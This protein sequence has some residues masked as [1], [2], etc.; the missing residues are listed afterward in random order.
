[1]IQ[2]Q[3]VPG[4]STGMS[5]GREAAP[6]LVLAAQLCAR[7]GR[8]T[9]QLIP[10]LAGAAQRLTAIEAWKPLCFTHVN[11]FA[12]ERL[13][14]SGSWLRQLARLGR[15]CQE[16]PA[17]TDAITGADGGK[18][19][20]RAA[21]YEICRVARADTVA[22]WIQRARQG[23]IRE[24]KEA[25]RRAQDAAPASVAATPPARAQGAL[26]VHLPPFLVCALLDIERVFRATNPGSRRC[27]L[28]EALTA[29]CASGNGSGMIDA[30]RDARAPRATASRDHNESVVLDT[31]IA[32]DK[33]VDNTTNRELLQ[34]RW[35]LHRV[36]LFIA[37]LDAQ[38]KAPESTS[39]PKHIVRS[40]REILALEHEV[41]LRI[42]QLLLWLDHRRAWSL[43]GTADA[44]DFGQKVLDESASTTRNRLRL[45][46]ALEHSATL[47]RGAESGQV[48]HQRLVRLAQLMKQR[49]LD[50][51][52]LQ[53]WVDHAPQIRIKRLDDEYNAIERRRWLSG[54]TG[55]GA[56][57]PLPLSDAEW[58]A[59]LRLVP[60]E[61][62]QRL[63]MG[64]LQALAI[65]AAA[66][67]CHRFTGPAETIR[68][69]RHSLNL[70]RVR[71]AEQG[72]QLVHS[73]HPGRGSLS[74]A[75]E[76][77]LFPSIRLAAR[78]VEHGTPIPDWVCLLSLLEEFAEEW[79]NPR[80][81]PRR[82]TDAI[83]ARDGWRCTAPGCTSREIEIHHIVYRSHGGSDDP[84]NL[85]SI[86]PFHHRMG[87]HGGLLKVTGTA[88]LALRWQIGE[89]VFV[90][91]R[92]FD[93]VVSETS[94]QTRRKLWRI[95]E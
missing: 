83:A 35:T 1:M 67:V 51:D 44:A 25:I 27:D 40:M 75:D 14:H 30:R 71:L 68:D 20:G 82:P 37:S 85:T 2:R 42:D 80:H 87:E 62:R 4:V 17:L 72:R 86:C 61:A 56:A 81:M 15:T 12:C 70:A 46:R 36:H 34:A 47:R 52:T 73:R 19:L 10:R 45:A 63:H 18:P 53:D 32:P 65:E 93:L 57:P 58:Q 5:T 94:N 43:L 76:A 24:L 13:D 55:T 69:L 49:K 22:D 59:S 90:N 64:A 66:N 77:R 28:L 9:A 6:E 26:P 54:G 16:M 33:L 48:S 50:E 38:T 3:T 31:E 23:T 78:H 21:A 95:A 41:K 88:P 84:S 39:S 29:E 89:C 91:E 60:G 74:P 92:A 11:D 7:L 79:D 8:C